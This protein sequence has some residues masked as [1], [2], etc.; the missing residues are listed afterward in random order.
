MAIDLKNEDNV[1]SEI[2]IINKEN[3]NALC[4]GIGGTGVIR[5][6]MILG[7]AALREG[8]KVR[9]AETHGMSQRG[10]SVCSYLRFGTRPGQ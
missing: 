9:T 5:V 10:G 3:Y 1:K 8:F 4:V 6:S 2:A 7:W